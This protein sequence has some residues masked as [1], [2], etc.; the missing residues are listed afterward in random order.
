VA[1]VRGNTSDR[2]C[3][4]WYKRNFLICANIIQLSKPGDRIVV[5]FGAGHAFLLRQCIG[6]TR[7]FKLVEP[8]D[9]LPG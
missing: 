6:Q 3:C 2:N 9:Y 1:G 7:G 5:L 8:N 4:P